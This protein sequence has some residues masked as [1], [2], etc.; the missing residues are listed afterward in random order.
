MALCNGLKTLSKRKSRGVVHS[1]VCMLCW[2]HPETVPHLIFECAMVKN[3][4]SQLRNIMGYGI[5]IAASLEEELQWLHR[6]S[7]MLKI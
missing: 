4:W 1:E 2:G 6:L 7:L 3:I 5:G